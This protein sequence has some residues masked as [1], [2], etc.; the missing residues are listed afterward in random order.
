MSYLC[1]VGCGVGGCR[2]VHFKTKMAPCKERHYV[3]ASYEK[4]C[5]SVIGRP[6]AVLC[7]NVNVF[8]DNLD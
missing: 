3:F 2:G 7:N 6:P 8:Y 1:L 4:L 5:D